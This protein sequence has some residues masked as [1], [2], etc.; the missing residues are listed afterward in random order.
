MERVH[1]VA[2]SFD[3]WREFVDQEMKAAYLIDMADAGWAVSDLEAFWRERWAPAAFVSWFGEK[4]GL[5]HVD[6][7][8]WR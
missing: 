3:G 7:T 5:T 6:D 2:L 1:S 4:Y 8:G